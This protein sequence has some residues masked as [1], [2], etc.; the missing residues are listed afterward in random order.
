[1]L[2]LESHILEGY[3]HNVLLLS[4]VCPIVAWYRRASTAEATAVYPDKY[5]LLRVTSL[6]LGPHVQIETILTV[7]TSIVAQYLDHSQSGTGNVCSRKR[8]NGRY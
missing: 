1:M 4:D 6:R 2:N 5:C 7:Y 8:L 3:H